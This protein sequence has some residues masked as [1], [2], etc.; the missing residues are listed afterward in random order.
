[1]SIE[2]DMVRLVGL[3]HGM[4]NKMYISTLP[5]SLFVCLLLELVQLF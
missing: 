4:P 3:A 1:M 2:Y 5:W